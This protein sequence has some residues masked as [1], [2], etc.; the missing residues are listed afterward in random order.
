MGDSHLT[1]KH[2]AA[3]RYQRNHRLMID[4]FGDTIVPDIRNVVTT[5]RLNLLK[6]QVES[7]TNH[8]VQ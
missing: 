5:Q 7:L 6:R 3:A 2:I 1:V 8:Q 4:V